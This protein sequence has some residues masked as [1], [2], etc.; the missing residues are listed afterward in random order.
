MYRDPV[1][2]F[3]SLYHNKVLWPP[4]PHPFYTKMR[5]EGLAL[6]PFLD[7]VEEVLQIRNA[8]HMDDHIRPQARC[9]TGTRM[10]MTV[11]M[12]GPAVR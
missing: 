1:D 6:D 9:C 10:R 5:L 2:R 8:L 4:N 12:A 7:V 3:L 11:L